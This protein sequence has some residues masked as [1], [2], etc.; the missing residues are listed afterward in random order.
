MDRQVVHMLKDSLQLQAQPKHQTTRNL[1]KGKPEKNKLLKF[2]GSQNY[3]LF[4]DGWGE[5]VHFQQI[6]PALRHFMCT[7]LPFKHSEA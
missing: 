6:L 7:F 4:V 1:H 3:F 2:H 5:V